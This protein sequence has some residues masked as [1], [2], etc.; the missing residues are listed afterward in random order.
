MEHLKYFKIIIPFLL[1]IASYFS[2]SIYDFNAKTAHTTPRT[3][4]DKR[5]H[6][7][8]LKLDDIFISVKT[9]KRF[10]TTRLPI[11][12]KT[13][14]QLAKQQTWFFTDTTSYILQ[15]RTNGHI[16]NT[17]C[18]PWHDRRGLNCKMEFEYN[19]YIKSGKKWF[20]HFDDDNYVNVFRLVSF[21]RKYDYTYYWYLGKRSKFKPKVIL[22]KK[23]LVS[24]DTDRKSVP[25]FISFATGGAGLCISRSLARRMFPVAGRGGFR[26]LC[27]TVGAS[28][29]VCVGLIVQYVT[30]KKPVRLTQVKE[31]HSHIEP[32]K[33]IP[34]REIRNQISFS[35]KSGNILN[36]PALGT[37][38][39]P[40]RFLSLHC[41]LYPYI[42]YCRNRKN[43]TYQFTS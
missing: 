22:P 8:D 9:S 35:Y 43:K 31:F 12:L 42:D 40:S 13:W 26:R 21:L 32:L 10:E 14:F 33:K 30:L 28:D 16:I 6:E 23:Y 37:F 3:T 39:D 41:K 27:R 15:K 24:N 20:C 7:S 4:T 19:H 34:V 36:I 2:L 18:S 29:D 5:N 38:D 17:K 25:L 11:I 1:V